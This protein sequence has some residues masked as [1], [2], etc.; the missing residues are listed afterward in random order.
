[1]NASSQRIENFHKTQRNFELRLKMIQDVKIRWNFIC[2][3]LLRA[4]RLQVFIKS[5][6]STHENENITLQKLSLNS[7]E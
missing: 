4:L 2:L 5:Y 1:M 6:I 7:E 3:M